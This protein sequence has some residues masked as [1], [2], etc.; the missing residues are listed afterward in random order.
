MSNLSCNLRFIAAIVLVVS[1]VA[2]IED[3]LQGSNNVAIIV[4]SS[5]NSKYCSNLYNIEFATIYYVL[6][7]SIC[8]RRLSIA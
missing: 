5:G 2:K 1:S 3:L 7:I 8:L 4:A 6:L